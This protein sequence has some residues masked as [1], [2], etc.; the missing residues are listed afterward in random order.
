[1]DITGLVRDVRTERGMT[2]KRLAE[3]LHVSERTVLRW[4]NGQTQPSIFQVACLIR[5]ANGQA[6]K[7]KLDIGERLRKLRLKRGYTQNEVDTRTG[8]T[9][10]NQHYARLERGLYMPRLP[11]LERVA[12]VLGVS[13]EE[14]LR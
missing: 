6:K 12:E 13:I 5:L 11:T 3:V 10:G 9:C 4:E 8:N 2:Q 14:L 7:R 1:M